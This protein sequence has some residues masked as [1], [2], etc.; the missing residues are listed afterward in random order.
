MADKEVMNE[1]ENINLEAYRDYMTV[2]SNCVSSEDLAELEKEGFNPKEISFED[3]VT[4]VD[5]IKA[6]VAKGGTN[7]IGYTDDISKE[8]LLE[9]TKDPAFANALS[10]KFIEKDIP[11]TED[12]V[13]SIVDNYDKLRIFQKPT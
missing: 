12:N 6:A 2:M 5:H 13:S 8:A 4:I 1:A 7:V 9:I 10:N 11:L 3:V